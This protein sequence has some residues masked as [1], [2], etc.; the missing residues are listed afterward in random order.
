MSARTAAGA[1]TLPREYYTDGDLF[2]EERERLFRDR[3][4]YAG[5]VSEFEGAGAFRR[6]DLGPESVLVV[7]QENGGLAAV[8][9]VCRHRGT[10]LCESEAGT[11]TGRIQ[12]PYHAWT[13]RLNGD[14]EAAPN[15]AEVS[16]FRREDFPL[17][18]AGVAEYEGFVFLRLGGTGADDP[19]LSKLDRLLQWSP[20]ALRSVHRTVYEVEANWK[21]FFQNY[22][23]CY[24]CPTV[25]P[26]LNRLTPYRDSSNDLEEGPVL[27]GPMKLARDGGS[28]TMTGERCAPPLPGVAGEDCNL[29]YY[30]TVFPNLFVSLHPDYVLVHRSE[31]LAVDRT[32]IHCDWLFHPEAIDDES[33]DPSGA[34]EFWDMTNRQDW[35]LCTLSQ[36]GISSSAYVPGPYAELESQLAAFDRYYLTEFEP[37]G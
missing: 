5:H 6:Y 20:A 27:G 35:H 11:F 19:A 13:Y 18:T 4:I 26:V 29:V 22:S 25:H 23:E 8:H 24:H 30:Y 2:A 32:R 9:N 14:L 7:R 28:M 33:F 21:L 36:Q 16:G 17:Q 15:M 12:C 10:R 34:I 1:F 31:P 37:S 3:W